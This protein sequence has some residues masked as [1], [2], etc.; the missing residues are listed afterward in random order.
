MSM[1]AKSPAGAV[2]RSTTMLSVPK[3]VLV[4][5]SRNCVGES[6]ATVRSVGG[7]MAGGP[8]DP[9]QVAQLSATPCACVTTGVD[10]ISWRVQKLLSSSGSTTVALKSPQ[11]TPELIVFE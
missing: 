10:A 5:V 9:H 11:R 7:S 4:Q 8:K 3:T 6:C 2:R 1:G